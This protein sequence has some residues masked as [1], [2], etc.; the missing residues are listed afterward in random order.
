VSPDGRF[1]AFADG[2]AGAR[3][4]HLLTTDGR[5]ASQL[6]NHPADDGNPIWSGNGKQ[7]AFISARNGNAALWVVDVNG[8][9]PGEP[10]RVK[11][12]LN[13]VSLIDW[14]P[15]G[16]VYTRSVRTSDIYTVATDA[17]TQQP[18][19]APQQ[20]PYARTGRNAGPAWA[21]D[22]RHLAFVSGTPSDPNRRLLVVLPANTGDPR[23][24]LIPTTRYAADPYDLRWFGDGSG[25]GFSGLD[26]QGQATLFRLSLSSG[27]WNTT[28]APTERVLRIEWNQT[29][30]RILY[31]RGLDLVE[32]DL[33]S[34]QERVIADRQAIF[35]E[36]ARAKTG[37]TS[38]AIT[39]FRGLRVS[40]DRRSLVLTSST[41]DGDHMAGLWVVNLQSG[42]PRLLHWERSAASGTT[43]VTFGSPTWSHDGRQLLL[44]RL[45]GATRWPDLRLVS[46]ETEKFRPLE[47]D[48]SF[49]RAALDPADVGT[50]IDGLALSPDGTRLA[51]VLTA[52]RRT[53]AW[54]L[55]PA[56]AV[57][58]AL[59]RQAP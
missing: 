19:G 55:E 44:P 9:K 52:N 20:L 48:R 37:G 47:L 13:G 2:T 3:D 46:V 10:I 33:E 54:I 14:T 15:R 8:G 39:A 17:A 56:V 58:G 11:E 50:L 51:F 45:T 59:K 31:V 1:I 21:P 12:S 32:R 5:T 26:A 36:A 23:E 53:E 34:G 25:V 40:P 24:F 7:I 29:G 22:G 27:E 16:V 57:A 42:A 4:I 49:V 6:T 28:P 41:L 38:Q 35:A 43:I 30:N 18:S